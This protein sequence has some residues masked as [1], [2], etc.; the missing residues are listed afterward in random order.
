MSLKR[1][2]EAEIAATGPMTVA[3]FMEACLHDP[4]DGYYATRPAL[5]KDGDFITA[6]L[7]SQMFGELVGLW[8]VQLWR[9]MGAP[10]PVRLIE[11]GPGDGTLMDDM[12]RAAARVAP[13]FLPAAEVW[14]VER[15]APLR[16]AQ[17]AR[18]ALHA[19][20]WADDL[21]GVPAGA[22]LILV[23]NE[24]LDCLPVRQFVRLADGWAERRVGRDA[25]GALAF[26]LAPAP[27]GF[28]PP[29]GLEDVAEGMIVE[30]SAAQERLGALVG[31]RI[32]RDG[33]G[34]LFIDYGR[35]RPGPGDTLQAL[36][37]HRKVSVLETP[38]EADLTVHA[39]FPAFAAAARAT[40][41]ET[42][43]IRTQAEFLEALGIRARAAALVAARPE[44]ADVVMRQ[45][46]RLTG[47]E[48]M[49]SLFKAVAIH[50][51]GLPVP[52]FE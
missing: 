41:V 23:A 16:E 28:R 4:R 26:G 33:G 35:G 44:K 18:L 37:A 5:G 45:L 1:R 32:G 30:V 48:A 17:A 50:S 29:A 2:L 52:G 21:D 40:G 3:A 38:G 11:M 39:D 9:T 46:D 34:A 27:G 36:S 31:D 13:A 14:L 19:P 7:V 8:A 12:L 20:K 49:G 15:S 6:P 10:N 25:E 47:T 22:P 42:T 43:P 51:P 24:L